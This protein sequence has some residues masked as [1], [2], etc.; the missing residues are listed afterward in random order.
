MKWISHIPLIGG[1]TIAGIE[2]LE[3][4]PE[5]ITSYAPFYENDSL[6]LRYTQDILKTNIPYYQLDVIGDKI[7]DNIDIVVGVPPCA[8]LSQ[9]SAYSVEQRLLCTTNDWMINS[10]H[11]VLKNIEPKVYVFENAPGLFNKMGEHVRNKINALAITYNY[12][13]VYYKTSSIKHGLPQDRT[14][15]YCFLVK[16]DKAPI[17]DKYNTKLIP[18]NEYLQLIPK[19]AS[20]QDTYYANKEDQDITQYEIYKY[21]KSLFGDEWREKI[22]GDKDLTCS[23]SFLRK[24]NLFRDFREYILQLPNF[25]NRILK[26]VEHIIYKLS[27]GKN[28]R[29]NRRILTSFKE[30]TNTVIA[31]RFANFTH[32][33]ID[34]AFNIREFLH[35]MGMP[36]DFELYNKKEFAKIAQNCPVTTNKDILK[37]C[38]AIINNERE[39]SDER[40]LFIDNLK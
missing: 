9:A 26:D 13:V 17:L 7:F 39:Y 25:D 30:Y 38:K 10:V 37:E 14:R 40:I 12:S 15:T 21:L 11:Y 16:G 32:P 33:T 6:L 23:Y 2:E 29:K 18:I 34:R 28:F 1:F 22:R 4:L 3:C 31:E 27:L 5:A 36:H 35:M 24:E 20:L 8:G 19:S